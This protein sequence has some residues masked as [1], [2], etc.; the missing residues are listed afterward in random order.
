MH[1]PKELYQ[2][3]PLKL[4]FWSPKIKNP[5]SEMPTLAIFVKGIISPR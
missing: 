3:I 1:H 4:D 2:K 5:L